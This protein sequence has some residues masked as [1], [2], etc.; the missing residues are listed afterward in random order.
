[1]AVGCI[2]EIYNMPLGQ[3]IT[4]EKWP[5]NITGEYFPACRVAARERNSNE[6]TEN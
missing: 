3:T 1:M 6:Q 5:R 4:R 2:S